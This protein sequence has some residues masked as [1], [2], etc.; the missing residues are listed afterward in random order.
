MWDLPPHPR[1]SRKV[2]VWL[3]IPKKKCQGVQNP[4]KK[5]TCPF[6]FLFSYKI[7]LPE[8]HSQQQ[9]PE[10]WY[11][12]RL[13]T[14]ILGPP[15]RTLRLKEGRSFGLIEDLIPQSIGLEV[16]FSICFFSDVKHWV[17]RPTNIPFVVVAFLPS[18][19]LTVFALQNG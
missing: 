3:V 17:E 9:A 12:G 8:P 11:F 1:N 13:Y 19:K 2:Q 5:K 7:T 18:L 6:G 15:L 10:N 14:F 16:W 4:N